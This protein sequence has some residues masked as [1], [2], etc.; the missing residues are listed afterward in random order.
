MRYTSST[1][2]LTAALSL[3]AGAFVACAPTTSATTV[4]AADVA[5]PASREATPAAADASF[6][7][8]VCRT[9]SIQEGTTELYL[10]WDGPSARGVL[11]RIAP[12]GNETVQNVK[13]ERFKGLIIADDTMTVDLVVHAATIA[14]HEG[15]P[16]IRLGDW[17]QP[18]AACE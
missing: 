18:W 4:T 2:L 15:K 13:A 8:L 5:A 14:Q 16:H 9:K 7:S 17:K 11:R 6:G 12:S 10:S 1:P 3:I